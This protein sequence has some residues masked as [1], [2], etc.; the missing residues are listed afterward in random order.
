MKPNAEFC[1][2]PYMLQLDELSGIELSGKFL[3][4]VYAIPNL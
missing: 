2:Y 1:K 4:G 3:Y